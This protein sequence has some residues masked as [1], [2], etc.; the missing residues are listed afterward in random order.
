MKLFTA[1]IILCPFLLYSQDNSWVKNITDEAGLSEAFG[2][3]IWIGDV[4]GDDYPDLLWGGPEAIKNDLH[5]MLNMPNPDGSSDIKRVF[6]D[7]T[8]ESGINTRRAGQEGNRISDIAAMADV[9]NDGDLDIVASI[10]Y[11]RL[12]YYEGDKDPGDRTEVLLNDGTGKFTLNETADLHTLEMHGS[13]LPEGLINTTGLAYFDYD[14]DGNIDL[15]MGTWFSDYAANIKMV[16]CLL[17]G[18]GDG[19][20]SRV[21]DNDIN[22]VVEP[23]YGVNATDW[24]NDGWPDIITSPYCR[25]GG[26]LFMNNGDGTFMDVAAQANYSAQHMGGDHGQNLCQWE[27]NPADFDNDGDMDILQVSVHGGYQSSEGRTLIAVNQGPEE[28]YR[29]EWDRSLLKRDAP[30]NTHVGDMGGTWFDIDNDG[31]LDVAIG[32]MSYPQANTEGQ[33]RLYVLKQNSGHSFD[34]ISKAIGIFENEKEAHTVE[35]VDFDLDGDLD[36][37]F[38]RNH[39]ETV[40]I[41]TVLDGKD[42]TI[43]KN[44]AYMKINL[45]RNDIGERNVWSA[46]K[47]KAPEGVNKSAIGAR[48]TT[49]SGTE[50]RIR[51]IQ[52]GLGHFAGHEAF[53]KSTGLGTND[54]IDS[55]VVSWPHIEHKKTTIYNPPR[56][57]ILQIDGDGNWDILKT[58]DEPAG[59][60]A[61]KSSYGNFDTVR[62]NEENEINF[63]VQNIGDADLNIQNFNPGQNSKFTL[64][65]PPQDVTLEPGGEIQLTAKFTPEE[66]QFYFGEVI[67]ESDAVN[68]AGRRF[69]LEGYGFEEKPLIALSS[70]RLRFDTVWTGNTKEMELTIE[71]YGELPL[72]ISDISIAD[73]GHG[74]FEIIGETPSELAAGESSSITI[75]FTPDPENFRTFRAD[76]NIASDAYRNEEKTVLLEAYSDGPK[77]EI[78]VSADEIDFGKVE[79]NNS[80]EKVIEITN[81]GQGQLKLE[82]AEILGKSDF[83]IVDFNPPVV[84]SQS[85]PKYDLRIRLKAEDARKHSRVMTIKS[86]STTSNS[87]SI[88]LVAEVVEPGSVADINESEF[89]SASVVPNPVVDEGILRLENNGREAI[90]SNIYLLS[91][92]GEN[93][94]EIFSGQINPGQNE[95]KINAAGL[96]SGKYFAIIEIGDEKFRLP[97]IIF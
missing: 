39:R 27:A 38:S 90:V 1:L 31:L 87:T 92:A 95:F 52:A 7:Y 75:R 3:R 36:I 64:V 78:A 61:Y 33:E 26:S 35:P 30:A 69:I 83:E 77:P 13:M 12:Q 40:Q 8:D 48:I 94:G 70:E 9:D 82:S 5:L 91:V 51:E 49:Y 81:S 80:Q 28:N 53:I 54:R 86:N 24:N 89:Y 45:L 65:N 76:L 23:M 42:T 62:V 2:S 50:Q 55:I 22:S 68:G 6:V 46:V 58:W 72:S 21:M 63:T 88:R 67:I 60:L 20:F 25:S 96:A 43:T 4:N 73:D 41:D 34:D 19:T 85:N 57:V 71:N 93:A 59:I 56:N 44:I 15:Y 74:L 10:Y 47:L 84:I 29:L 16:D 11:H 17:K 97:V 37:M 79:L 18:N 32:Q 14:L 66:R